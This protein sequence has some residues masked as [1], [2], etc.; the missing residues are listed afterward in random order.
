MVIDPTELIPE[1]DLLEQQAPLDPGS[2]TGADTV[3][4]TLEAGGDTVEEG[5]WL[6][7]HAEVPG[8]DDY[9]HE[10]AGVGSP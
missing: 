8:D 5:D 2:L 1:A 3:S 10:T 9:P 4:A 6:E 7:Q